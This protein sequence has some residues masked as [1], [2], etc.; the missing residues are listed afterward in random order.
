MKY[1][2]YLIKKQFTHDNFEILIRLLLRFPAEII[3]E[4]FSGT[5]KTFFFS[6]L[7]PL[8]LDYLPRD[9]LVGLKSMY[10]NDNLSNAN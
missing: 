3:S 7:K 9:I 10:Y 1:S 8:I 5:L 2:F 4:I 6:D